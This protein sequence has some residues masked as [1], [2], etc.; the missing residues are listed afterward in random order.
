MSLE[1][2]KLFNFENQAP[3]WLINRKK[4]LDDLTHNERKKLKK[5]IYSTSY[6]FS[7]S[8]PD[9]NLSN[10]LSP[11]SPSHMCKDCLRTFKDINNYKEHRF[12]E[13][14]ITEFPNIRQC[15]M[16]SYA[17]LLKSKYDCHM[18]CHLNNK[19]IK[20]QRCSY[21]TINIRHMSKHERSHMMSLKANK[22]N[23]NQQAYESSDLS[24]SL[25]ININADKS[26]FQFYLI[27]NLPDYDIFCCQTVFK[28]SFFIPVQLC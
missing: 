15:K 5:N 21:S 2:S 20:C 23:S 16:C 1:N 6:V 27:Y 26:K 11:A 13:H 9:E 12:Q 8:K 3:D 18:R 28:N 17:T 25:A 19:V 10:D 4:Q 7:S 22:S 14:Q 24:E